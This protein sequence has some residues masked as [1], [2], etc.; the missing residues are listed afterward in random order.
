MKLTPAQRIA[1]EQVARP[2][3]RRVR[4][5]RELTDEERRR[6]EARHRFEDAAAERALRDADRLV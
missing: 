2:E 5:P 1:H 3:H 6:R 4:P